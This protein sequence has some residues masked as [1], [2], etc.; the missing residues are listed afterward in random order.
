MHMIDHKFTNCRA[1]TGC[2]Y[3]AE[4]GACKKGFKEP[5]CC[6]C[7]AGLTLR[8]GQCHQGKRQ[9]HKN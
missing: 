8:N 6:Q 3:N 2:T 7:E 5:D 9:L 1:I 4:N